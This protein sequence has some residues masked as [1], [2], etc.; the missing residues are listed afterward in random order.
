M[1][2]EELRELLW[3]AFRAGNQVQLSFD[4]ADGQCLNL[5]DKFQDEVNALVKNYEGLS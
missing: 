1:D 3:W 4:N 2:K 5:L